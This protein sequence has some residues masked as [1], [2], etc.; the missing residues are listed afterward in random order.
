MCAD[1]CILAIQNMDFL[2]YSKEAYINELDR[3]D[4]LRKALSLPMGFSVVFAGGL[5]SLFKNFNWEQTLT[6]ASILFGFTWVI[7][8]TLLVVAVCYLIRSHIGYEYAYVPTPKEIREYYDKLTEY[9]CHCN[10]NSNKIRKS[11]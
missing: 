5:F 11:G 7:G 10:K 8:F 3:R 6:L 2:S 4:S 9:L 1:P